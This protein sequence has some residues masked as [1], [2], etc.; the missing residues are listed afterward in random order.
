V[1]NFIN[2]QVQ[3]AADGEGVSDWLGDLF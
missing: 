2:D 1:R 3:E